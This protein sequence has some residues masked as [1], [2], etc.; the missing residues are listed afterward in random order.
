VARS[1]TDR[2]ANPGRAVDAAVLP[3]RKREAFMVT[4]LSIAAVVVVAFMG[5]NLYRRFGADRIRALTAQM[6]GAR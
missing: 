1:G 5:W 4:W 6:A 2:T 3:L